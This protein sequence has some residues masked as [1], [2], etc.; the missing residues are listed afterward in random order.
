[1][2]TTMKRIGF[3]KNLARLFYAIAATDKRVHTTEIRSLKKRIRTDWPELIGQENDGHSDRLCQ[4]EFEFDRLVEE[5]SDPNR[6]FE[7]FVNFKSDNQEEFTQEIREMIWKTA[8]SIALSFSGKNKSEMI[9]L[10]KL[11][12]NLLQ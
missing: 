10:T 8:N 9:L 12:M 5:N 7:D 2:K 3:C 4:I 11:K 1:M 6:C